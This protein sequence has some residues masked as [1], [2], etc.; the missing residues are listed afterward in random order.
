[1]ERVRIIVITINLKY[2]SIKK[3]ESGQYKNVHLLTKY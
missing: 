3:E 2:T 1:M